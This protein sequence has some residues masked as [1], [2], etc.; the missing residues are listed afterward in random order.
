VRNYEESALSIKNCKM[1]FILRSYYFS[2]G[3]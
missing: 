3:V 1:F 2:R